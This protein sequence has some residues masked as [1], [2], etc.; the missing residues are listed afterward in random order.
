MSVHVYMSFVLNHFFFFYFLVLL[1]AVRLLYILSVCFRMSTFF[2]AF[3][4]PS[5]ENSIKDKDLGTECNYGFSNYVS[6]FIYLS[7]LK[8]ILFEFVFT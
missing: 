6:L 7:P 1:D 4:F 2:K 3:S 8:S 5:M